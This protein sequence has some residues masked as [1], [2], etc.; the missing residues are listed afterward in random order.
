MIECIEIKKKY[1]NS[2][3]HNSIHR[4]FDEDEEAASDLAYIPAPGSPSADTP[5]QPVSSLLLHAI[6][7]INNIHGNMCNFKEIEEDSDEE[8]P[9]DAYMMGIEKHLETEKTKPIPDVAA[10]IVKSKGTRADI[11]DEDDEESYYR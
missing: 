7:I 9:L 8:D 3:N 11:D 1:V 2:H 5:T 4:Y 10:T 6:I